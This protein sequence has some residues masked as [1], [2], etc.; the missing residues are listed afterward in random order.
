MRRVVRGILLRLALDLRGE[1]GEAI[2]T[3]Y[4]SWDSSRSISGAYDPGDHVRA[5]AAADLGLIQSSEALP[6]L[7]Q[8][9][10]DPA[11]R[12]RQTAVWAVGQA[13]GPESWPV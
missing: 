2:A 1:T 9:L 5:H 11:P 6:C 3:L 13:G 7:L 10:N 12:V 8:C 4:R